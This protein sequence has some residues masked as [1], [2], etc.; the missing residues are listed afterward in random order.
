[1]ATTV[2]DL[3]KQV[4]EYH[5]VYDGESLPPLD[6]PIQ[7]LLAANGVFKRAGTPH[8]EAMAP[9]QTLDRPLPGLATLAPGVEL[10]IPRLPSAW[11]TVIL[12]V[13]RRACVNGL[14]EVM[15]QVVVRGRRAYLEM[16]SQWATAT[17]LRYRQ[18]SD[19]LCDLHSHHVM[20]PAFSPTDDGDET[21]L[22][23]Y[24]VMG[25]I[26]GRP[27][28]RLR[29]GVYGHHLELPVTTLFEGTGPFEDAYGTEAKA[30]KT[31]PRA[32]RGTG[33]L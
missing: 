22:R 19:V 11:L 18:A 1:M 31:V 32:G 2:P 14:R 7:Y 17:R 26:F 21:G 33:L 29:V 9:V 27:T 3:T 10:R 8:F 6:T 12:D 5:I 23:F 16:P 24:A 4:A 25:R 30:R 20:P 15:F 28:I 13:S